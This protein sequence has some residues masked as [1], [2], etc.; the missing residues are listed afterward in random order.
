MTNPNDINC[1]QLLASDSF[2][3]D[4]SNACDGHFLIQ[5]CPPMFVSVEGAN[6]AAGQNNIRC[7]DAA[8]RYPD[9]IRYGVNID[10]FGCFSGVSPIRRSFSVIALSAISAILFHF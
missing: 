3:I 2:D 7:I 4:L 8:C 9:S 6:P 1:R 5:Q 10:N